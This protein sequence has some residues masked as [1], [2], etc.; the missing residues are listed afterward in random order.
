MR[1]KFSVASN[2]AFHKNMF[3][4]FGDMLHRMM[5]IRISWHGHFV[6]QAQSICISLN[7]RNN[8]SLHI[9]TEFLRF[10]CGLDVLWWCASSADRKRSLE[11]LLWGFNSKAE[12]LL[13]LMSWS[14]VS[15]PWW[16]I[17]TIKLSLSI[18]GAAVSPASLFR[19][20]PSPGSAIHWFV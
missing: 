11:A 9:P 5:G 16:F 17:S 8:K 19:W 2:T 14:E 10:S 1:Y 20:C 4:L 13:R 6:H 7:H 12:L 3:I 15:D 18:L